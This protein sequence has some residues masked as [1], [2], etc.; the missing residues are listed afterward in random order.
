MTKEVSG[1]KYVTL[2]KVIAYCRIMKSNVNKLSMDT[3]DVIPLQFAML[4][5]DLKTGL[6]DKIKI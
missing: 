2:S 1:E 3:T 4:I 5:E 6:D